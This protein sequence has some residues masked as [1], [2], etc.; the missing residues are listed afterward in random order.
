MDIVI[1]ESTKVEGLMKFVVER[2]LREAGKQK[3]AAG[4]IEVWGPQ[5]GPCR[6]IAAVW[7]GGA[8]GSSRRL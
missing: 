3:E 1:E 4:A 7:G 5:G 8:D 2:E 6:K